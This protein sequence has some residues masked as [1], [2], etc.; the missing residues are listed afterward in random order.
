M[1]K[2]SMD[3]FEKS[4]LSAMRKD[5]GKTKGR[6]SAE[7]IAE[8]KSL[9]N[10]IRLTSTQLEDAQKRRVQR[11]QNVL[12]R[13]K[14]LQRIVNSREI[15]DYLHRKNLSRVEAV[16]R[17]VLYV[18]AYVEAGTHSQASDLS[19]IP[20]SERQF[21]QKHVP[22]FAAALDEAF[23][24]VTEDLEYMAHRRAL[25]KSDTLL[26]FLL[27]ARK[28]HVYRDRS[29]MTINAG[30]G[31]GVTFVINEDSMSPEEIERAKEMAQPKEV[32]N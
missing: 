3:D 15:F 22:E 2:N 25:E 8:V 14:V 30:M 7:E 11:I 32:V 28:P 29:D 27:R 13:G 18:R 6:P 4:V 21:Y 17:M 19:G 26:T 12:D 10:G 23:E 20:S 24:M 31:T 9:V 1:S 5:A 16:K